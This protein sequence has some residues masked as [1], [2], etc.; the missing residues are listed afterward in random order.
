MF[1]NSTQSLPATNAMTAVW[2]LLPRV[3]T[4]NLCYPDHHLYGCLQ[5]CHHYGLGITTD[6][7]SI[8]CSGNTPLV[9][10][11]NISPNSAFARD[12]GTPYAA[13][14]SHV[15]DA[16]QTFDPTILTILQVSPTLD[17]PVNAVISSLV[18]SSLL[19]LINIGST[20]AFNSLVSLTNGVLMVSYSVCIGCFVWRRL[21]RQPMLP[22]RFNLGA[23]GLPVNLL[24]MAFLAV[25]FVMVSLRAALP[26]E[27]PTWQ[28][29]ET[30]LMCHRRS[31]RRL[32]YRTC[33]STL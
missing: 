3:S 25:V 5:C 22:S 4:Y 7:V 31:S 17:V 28:Q 29:H 24:A 8:C 27:A 20:V 6:V 1:Y 18:I 15:R 9:L 2:M 30:A 32:R 10:H 21:S 23:L 19:S 26:K 12:N 14:L 16:S 13:W 33:N 11:A